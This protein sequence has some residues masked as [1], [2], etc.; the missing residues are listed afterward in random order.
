M[1]TWPPQEKTKTAQ[2][3]ASLILHFRSDRDALLETHQLQKT[4]SSRIVCLV[5]T[6]LL[7]Y[8]SARGVGAAPV[9]QVVVPVETRWGKGLGPGF[10][11]MSGHRKEQWPK[12]DSGWQNTQKI[13]LLCPHLDG[14]PP[15]PQHSRSSYWA[16]CADHVPNWHKTRAGPRRGEEESVFTSMRLGAQT[17]SWLSFPDEW[18][19]VATM[20][21]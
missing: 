3:R 15:P 14:D 7:C 9:S 8:V 18:N 12:Q 1:A 19:G 17:Q 16:W 5:C 6:R 11:V 2:I 21:R 10:S 13:R 20:F 4:F